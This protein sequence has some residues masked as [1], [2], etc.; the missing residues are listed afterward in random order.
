MVL[1][2]VFQDRE[3]RLTYWSSFSVTSYKTHTH[4]WPGHHTHTHTHTLI[5]TICMSVAADQEMTFPSWYPITPMTPQVR[6]PL[7][8]CVYMCI[9][10]VQIISYSTW[11][12]CWDMEFPLHFLFM[13]LPL[14][15][16]PPQSPSLF[17]CLPLRAQRNTHCH[18]RKPARLSIYLSIHPSIHP[19]I[20]INIFILIITMGLWNYTAF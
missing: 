8:V 2:D 5:C 10:S 4:H 1:R 7:Y 3:S 20:Y 12:G 17:I 16:P 13:P 6:P 18:R 11:E 15:L 19:S 9:H 14:P